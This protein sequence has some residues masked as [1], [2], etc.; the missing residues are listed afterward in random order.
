[1]QKLMRYIRVNWGKMGGKR[2][3]VG[4][5]RGAFVNHLLGSLGSFRFNFE[6]IGLGVKLCYFKNTSDN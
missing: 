6:I 2:I 1:M 5:G 4:G 3:P